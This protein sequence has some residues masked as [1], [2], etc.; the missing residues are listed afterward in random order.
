MKKFLNTPFGS[1]T[2]VFLAAVL[3]TYLILLSNGNKLFTW[4]KD[5][6]EHL[7]TAG[8]VSAIPVIINWIN[9]N[10]TRYG[11]KKTDIKDSDPDA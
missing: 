5:M 11:I 2:K 1:F 9:P 3:T 6:L 10:D 4:N 7:L 8:L